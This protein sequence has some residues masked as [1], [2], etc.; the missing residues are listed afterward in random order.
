MYMFADLIIFF[1]IYAFAGWALECIFVSFYEK[2]LVNR[3]FLHGCFCPVYGFGG[4]L[5]IA[6]FKWI[7][8]IF[9]GYFTGIIIGTAF[10]ILT[11]TV[12]EYITGYLL[13]KIFH[14]KWWD[15]SNEFANI[16]GYICLKNSLIWGLL[17]V[18]LVLVANPLLERLVY[19]F[20]E[21]VRLIAGSM[22]L[23]YFITDTMMS[24][25]E[26]LQLRNAI[27]K[28]AVIPIQKYKEVVIRYKRFFV[29][30]PHLLKLNAGV[31]NRDVRSILNERI[32]WAKDNIKDNIKKIH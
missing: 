24:V 29:A 20:T 3:G 16:H 7:T 6:A 26:T 28:H 32:K 18:V 17:A 1:T 4:L 13:E 11:V 15:Y 27:V 9:T 14:C 31:I 12:L 8:T 22:F 5:I 2:K 19:H 25:I 21:Q 30:F 23:T 10:S